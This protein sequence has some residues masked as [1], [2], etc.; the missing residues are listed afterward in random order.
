MAREKIILGFIWFVFF[1]VLVISQIGQVPFIND[2]NQ[3][4]LWYA[5]ILFSILFL[6]MILNELYS[7]VR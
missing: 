4:Y 1:S 5:L 7:L 3:Q 2:T 6:A